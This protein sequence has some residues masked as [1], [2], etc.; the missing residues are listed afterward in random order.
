MKQLV[1]LREIQTGLQVINE[2]ASLD[3]T[4]QSFG[5]ALPARLHHEK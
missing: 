4:R 2:N 3:W 1:Y 5:V